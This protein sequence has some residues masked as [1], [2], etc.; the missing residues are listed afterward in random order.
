MFH[1]EP[2]RPVNSPEPSE[3]MVDEV[4]ATVT[5]GE[6]PADHGPPLRVRDRPRMSTLRRASSLSSEMEHRRS[7]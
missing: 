4:L 6:T 3:D 5:D 1:P 2:S 7:E